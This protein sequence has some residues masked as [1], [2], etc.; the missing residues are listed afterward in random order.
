MVRPATVPK[1][2]LRLVRDGESTGALELEDIYRTYCRY[3]GAIVLRL[4]GRKAELDDTIQ[5]VFIEAARGLG[6]VRD[7]DAIRGWLATIAVRV[8]QRRLRRERLYRWFI[9]GREADYAQIADEG[10]S[11]L[12]RMLIARVYEILDQLA[13]D[14]RI[15]FALHHIEGET[16]E[17]V[18]TLCR[19]S[20]TTAKRR[21]LRARLELERRLTHD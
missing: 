6:G 3:V 19:C 20:R 13:V 8:V 1:P 17:A 12:D 15:A 10:A 5:D 11:A 4:S 16:L 14:D 7:A 2:P 9:P 18:A 21:I